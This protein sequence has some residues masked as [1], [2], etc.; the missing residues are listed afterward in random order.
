M[1][2]VGTELA[3]LVLDEKQFISHHHVV[4]S[5]SNPF[6]FGG[7]LPRNKRQNRECLPAVKSLLNL[8]GGVGAA[9]AYA[10]GS[11]RHMGPDLGHYSSRVVLA[12]DKKSIHIFCKVTFAD[13]KALFKIYDVANMRQCHWIRDKWFVLLDIL[14]S[15]KTFR[16]AFQVI[17]EILPLFKMFG[18]FL[19]LFILFI[20]E[21]F[22][23][24][25]RRQH[26]LLIFHYYKVSVW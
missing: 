13:E 15:N 1:L 18:V 16:S 5:T 10:C 8:S 4:F 9:T 26:H 6:V 12:H 21:I 23:I 11:S 20:C 14:S 22:L 2:F 3:I 25:F 17:N 24:Y 7:R 19:W